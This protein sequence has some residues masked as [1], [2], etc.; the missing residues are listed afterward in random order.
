[1]AKTKKHQL[2]HLSPQYHFALNPYPDLR[3]SRGPDCGNKTGQRKLPLLIHIEQSHP[4]A[5]YFTCR[6]CQNC[7]TLICHKDDLEHV[8]STLFEQLDPTAIGNEYFILGTVEKTAWREGVTHP[9]SP[10]EMLPQLHDFKSYKELRMTVGGLFKVGQEP[11][12]WTPPPPTEWV[13][14]PGQ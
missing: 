7:D 3:F 2:G 11:P 4:I 12:V 14:R 10:A 6:Y 9:K 5:L 13:K 8:L 1:M